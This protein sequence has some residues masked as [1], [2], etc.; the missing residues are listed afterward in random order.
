MMS[1]AQTRQY[2]PQTRSLSLDDGTRLNILDWRQYCQHRDRPCA[3]LLH[4]FTNNSH[5]WQPLADDI[6]TAQ[7]LI[8]IDFRGHGDSDWDPELRYQH[9]QLMADVAA[10]LQQLAIGQHHLIGHSLGARIALLLAAEHS[11]KVASLTLIDTGP[12]VGDNGAAKVRVDAEAMQQ[13]FASP[14][15]FSHYLK[16]IYVFAQAA[17]VAALCRHGLKAT[18]DGRYRVKT[19]PGFAKVLWKPGE[20]RHDASDLTAPKNQQLWLALDTID[21]AGIRCHV[22][23]GSISAILRAKTANKMLEQHLIKGGQLTTIK[24]AGHAVICDNPGDTVA[25]IGEFLMSPPRR[26]Q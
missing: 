22:I 18:D 13:D 8:A 17:A 4:G 20:R 5:I 23:R 25:A 9:D 11:D 14:E 2:P 12:D 10:V 26:E 7:P 6:A 15:A 16:S 1:A 21:A 24:R 19:D 3:I